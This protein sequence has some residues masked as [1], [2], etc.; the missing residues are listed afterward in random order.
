MLQY[1]IY[2]LYLSV[3]LT[4]FGLLE[5]NIIFFGSSLLALIYNI[6]SRINNI[7]VLNMIIDDRKKNVKEAN[8]IGLLYKIKFILYT[9]LTMFAVAFLV[10][11]C[12]GPFRIMKTLKI[13]KIN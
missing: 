13:I 2:E 10:L 1:F 12:F 11:N 9:L 3:I 6:Y 4:I 8:R 5:N 7:Y